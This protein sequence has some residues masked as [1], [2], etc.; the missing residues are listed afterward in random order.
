MQGATNETGRAQHWRCAVDRRIVGRMVMH[1]RQQDT[2]VVSLVGAPRVATR[3]SEIQY[4]CEGG[5]EAISKS[6]THLLCRMKPYNLHPYSLYIPTNPIYSVTH[7][8]SPPLNRSLDPYS[9]YIPSYSGN[10]SCSPQL[11]PYLHP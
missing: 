7:S 10:Q 4:L 1:R 3:V 2:W 5:R 8:R 6:L 11:N 9:L